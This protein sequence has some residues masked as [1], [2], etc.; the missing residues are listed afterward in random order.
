[1]HMAIKRRH[2]NF[3]CHFD[4]HSH[5]LYPFS[6]V[7]VNRLHVADCCYCYVFHP[8]RYEYSFA[9][10]F[11]FLFICCS[12]VLFLC[13]ACVVITMFHGWTAFC[14]FFFYKDIIHHSINDN[15]GRGLF[16]FGMLSWR[17]CFLPTT[18]DH[19][20]SLYFESGIQCYIIY[21]FLMCHRQLYA[22]TR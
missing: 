11:F 21:M 22:V 5:S 9:F 15:C 4:L 17:F 2:T 3:V 14:S 16:F 18:P 7:P 13:S 20:K 1:M 12:C 6:L 10:F 19:S 8:F